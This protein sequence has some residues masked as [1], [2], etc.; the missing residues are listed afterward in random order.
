MESE[1][2]IK[3][4]AELARRMREALQRS[5]LSQTEV[6]RRMGES[7]ANVNRWVNVKGTGRGPRNSAILNFANVVGTTVEALT[8]HLSPGEAK[9]AMK[10]LDALQRRE[11]AP[12]AAYAGGVQPTPEFTRA[13]D[14]V[15]V[16]AHE[17]LD[18]VWAGLSP[19]GKLEVL[20]DLMRRR[21]DRR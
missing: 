21:P 2:R 12:A 11:G 3:E 1:A 17:Y 10:S 18:T 7:V 13:A 6:A 20:A 14:Q 9:G 5:G 19:E 8:G 4:K 15:L 16:A